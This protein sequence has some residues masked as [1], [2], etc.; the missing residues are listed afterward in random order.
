MSWE[1]WPYEKDVSDALVE[2]S[3]VLAAFSTDF[4]EDSN[5]TPN[6]ITRLFHQNNAIAGSSH[7]PVAGPS[8]RE[9]IIAGQSDRNYPVAGPSHR[10]D[11]IAGPSHR[12]YPVAGPSHREDNITGPSDQ[13]G[14]GFSV[15]SY[16]SLLFKINVITVLTN[17]WL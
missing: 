9:D 12:T 17:P 14:E 8:H 15:S 1:S 3:E 2:S 16:L 10:E 5:N 7:H 13:I 4:E 6:A 11:N